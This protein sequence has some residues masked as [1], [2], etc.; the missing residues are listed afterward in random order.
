MK[1][2]TPRLHVQNNSPDKGVAARAAAK[3]RDAN[4]RYIRH[5]KKIARH[6]P[7]DLRNLGDEQLLHDADFD[8]PRMI[9]PFPLPWGPQFVTIAARQ[10][11]TLVAEFRNTVAVLFYE[12][13]E[14]PIFETPVIHWIY[15]PA[16]PQWLYDEVDLIKPKL[17]SHEILVSDGR[18]IKIRFHD[19]HYSIVPLKEEKAAAKPRKPARRAASA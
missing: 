18:V 13:T 15:H 6:L 3:W 12:V 2:F 10:I 5:Y 9:R 7:P 8:G 14:E 1:Y 19:F 16:R 11:H 17:F 4:K